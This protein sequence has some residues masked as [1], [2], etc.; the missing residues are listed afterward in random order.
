M[1]K[2]KKVSEGEMDA[3]AQE[4]FHAMV[5]QIAASVSERI[6]AMLMDDMYR[7]HQNGTWDDPDVAGAWAFGVLEGLM[8]ALATAI[9]VHICKHTNALTPLD[10]GFRKM[11]ERIRAGLRDFFFATRAMEIG[12]A[13]HAPLTPRLQADDRSG[14]A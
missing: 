10:P 6:L 4:E 9:T 7:N 3:K 11:I 13:A 12:E 1:A 2:A 14:H 5:N 8:D